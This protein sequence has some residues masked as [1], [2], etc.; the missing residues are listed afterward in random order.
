MT[1]SLDT[2]RSELRMN[3]GVDDTD[4]PDADADLLLNRTYWEL[5]EK[6]HIRETESSTTITTVAGTRTYALP[7]N[8]ESL[9]ISSFVDPDSSQHTQLKMFTIKEYENLYNASSEEEAPPTHYFRQGSDI[10]FWP[11]PDDVYT[12]ILYYRQTLDDLS[13]SN[14]DPQLPKSWQELLILGAVYRGFLRFND[15]DKANSS[16]AHYVGQLNSMI[17]VESKEEWDTSLAGVKLRGRT[18]P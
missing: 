3:L 18:Y 2:L 15:Y 14:T 5:L 7:A 12:L 1:I 10:T 9:R 6:F 13:D 4:L 11:T 17:P 8:F 16:K